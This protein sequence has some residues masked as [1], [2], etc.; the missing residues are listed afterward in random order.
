MIERASVVG[1]LAL[2]GDYQKHLEILDAAG[3]AGRAVRF[4]DD[5]ERVGRLIIPGGESTVIADLI[6]RLGL[7]EAFSTF[8]NSNPVW[9][10]C[11]GMILLA[12]RVED[13]SI[14]PYGAI[15]IAVERNGYG[16]QVHSL[17]APS[18]IP[19]N[20][21]TKKLDLVFIRAPRVTRVGRGVTT[22]L[23]WNGDPVLLAQN[24]ILVSAFHPELTG[25][26]VLHDYFARRFPVAGAG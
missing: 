8:I 24:N 19:L 6:V 10:T 11:A 18:T 26:T 7:K 17:V 16:R 9:G 21:A 2:Q 13:N 25:S 22:L 3:I 14:S 15:D 5:F 23:T 20:G 12:A 1:V 4:A